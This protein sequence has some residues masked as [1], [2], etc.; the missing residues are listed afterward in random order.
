M[1]S[2][3]SRPKPATTSTGTAEP[4]VEKAVETVVAA[5]RSGEPL[6]ACDDEEWAAV[7]R[8]VPR[9]LSRTLRSR[10]CGR[11]SKRMP[12]PGRPPRAPP[13]RPRRRSPRVGRPPA[14]PARARTPTRARCAP[15]PERSSVARDAVVD[16]LGDDAA[17]RRRAARRP[18]ACCGCGRAAAS[19]GIRHRRQGA[20]RRHRGRRRSSSPS[21]QCS[22]T[23][24]PSTRG[25]LMCQP[26]SGPPR[27]APQRIARAREGAVVGVE[28]ARRRASRTSASSTDATPGT[29]PQSGSGVSSSTSNLRSTSTERLALVARRLLSRRDGSDLV[30]GLDEPELGLGGPVVVSP[31]CSSAPSRRYTICPSP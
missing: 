13:P 3:S 19:G 18:C 22:S 27:A 1:S 21:G 7:R 24:P 29:A 30:G 9:A 23:R 11:V 10:A 17:R 16:E 8:R 25:P 26:A 20:R 28:V 5:V 2:T 31:V 14:R 4:L 15:T 6:P 12:R